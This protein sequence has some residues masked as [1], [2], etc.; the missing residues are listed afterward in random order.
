MNMQNISNTTKLEIF[1]VL[2]TGKPLQRRNLFKKLFKIA[3]FEQSYSKVI[4][5]DGKHPRTGRRRA[6]VKVKGD[7]I[8]NLLL[9]EESFKQYIA[10]PCIFVNDMADHLNINYGDVDWNKIDL[11]FEKL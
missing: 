7:V 4:F 6:I 3:G 9:L 11:H 10:N 8:S 5:T 1:H 2:K